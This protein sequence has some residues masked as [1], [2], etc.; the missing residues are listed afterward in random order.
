LDVNGKITYQQ[1]VTR[2][3]EN[4]LPFGELTLQNG[5][6]I[7]ISQHGG[8]IFGPFLS[9]DSDSIFWTNDAL[10]QPDAFQEFLRS[11]SWNIGGDRMW[12]AP[13][14]QYHVPDRD[15]FWGTV[16]WPAQVDP[17]TYALEHPEPGQWLLSQDMRLQAYNL[18]S[19]QKDLHLERLIRQVEDPLRNVSGY[20]D[21]VDGVLFAGYEQVVTLVE[22][23][24]DDIV[25]EAWS[26]SQL[27]PGGV[28]VIPASP[29][30]EY[31]DYYEP[32]DESHQSILPGH[33]R[34]RITGQRQ[35]KVGYRAAHVFGRLGYY[36]HL[37]DRAYLIVRNFFNNPSAPYA[38]EP[39]HSPGCRGHSIHVYNDSGDFG[40][41]GELECNLPT[42]GGETGRSSSTDELV[43]W[44]YIGAPD[45]VKE[46]GLHLLGIEL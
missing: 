43:L 38:E 36:N 11:G 37:D 21:L 2:L 45:K 15:D 9:E 25:S 46:I 20:P 41:F 23:E 18:A 4:N 16:F 10:A 7:V 44:L 33:V 19:G 22:R 28:L 32:V 26:L 17:G 30:V 35:Y 34:L 31:T 27:N 1:V 12:I 6:T 5:V 24:R 29:R 42:I 13:E 14:I 3:E 39:D 40:G 8:R